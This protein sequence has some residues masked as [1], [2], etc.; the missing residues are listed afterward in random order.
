MIFELIVFLLV[1]IIGFFIR[2]YLILKYRWVG[3]DTFYHF[4]VAKTIQENGFPPDHIEKFVKPE[5]YNYPPVFH[6][7]LSL[8]NERKYQKLQIL[9][10]FADI[11]TSIAVFLFC[12]AYFS[13]QVAIISTALYIL[14]PFVLDNAYSFNPRSFANLFF[15]LAVF[16]CINMVILNSI[17]FFALSVIFSVLVL[18]LHRLTTQCL[19]A[20]LIVFAFGLH[21]FLPGIVFLLSVLTA[22]LMT[23]GFYLTVLR[24]HLAF[25]SEFGHKVFDDKKRDE[26]PPFFPDPKQLIF[27][28]PILPAILL[29]FYYPLNL[30]NPLVSSFLIWVL[31]L[32]VLSVIWIIGEGIRHMICS[33]PAFSILIAL[34]VTFYQLYSILLFIIIISV[35]F[36]I[37]KIYRLEK[38]PHISGI[39]KKNMLNAFTF[40]R[41]NK[42]SG[43]ILLCLPLDYSYNAAFF[44]DC[45][46]LQSSGGFA[47]GLSFNQKLHKMVNQGKINSIIE[48]YIPDWLVIL[49]GFP[50]GLDQNIILKKNTQILNFGD[51][52][53]IRF[54]GYDKTIDSSVQ[55]K[56]EEIR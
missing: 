53:V 13:F 16:S 5:N 14:T 4:I 46:V 2:S 12:N 42:K 55:P 50:K 36:S 34:I 1:L 23:K 35:L 26:L 9:S 3:K 20:V 18:L 25:I 22:I 33:V 41:K 49:Q 10:P 43:D 21:S 48:L 28:M 17:T 56:T 11:L 45:V 27:N 52:T 15:V 29:W 6:L 37:I 44:T 47:E 19:Y 40:I 51:S 8:F 30:Q 38:Y 39:T 54:I 7:F 31:I 32:T 24:G